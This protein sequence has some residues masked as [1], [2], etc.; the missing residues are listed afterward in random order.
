MSLISLAIL[1]WLIDQIGFTLVWRSFGTKIPC[2]CFVIIPAGFI[3]LYF[4]HA[5]HQCLFST[6]IEFEA[7]TLPQ[8][9]KATKMI[10][11]LVKL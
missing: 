8:H 4:F 10:S 1:G 3:D 2:Y 11:G 7:M 5:A 9:A 6:Q